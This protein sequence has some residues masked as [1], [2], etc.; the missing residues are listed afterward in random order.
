MYYFSEICSWIDFT[1]LFDFVL[2]EISPELLIDIENKETIFSGKTGSLF[3]NTKFWMAQD[4]I[5]KSGIYL[6]LWMSADQL[7]RLYCFHLNW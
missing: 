6:K 7:F 1:L 5:W 4:S 3:L 2:S